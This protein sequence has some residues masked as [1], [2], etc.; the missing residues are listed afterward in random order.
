MNTKKH[1]DKE[2]GQGLAEYALILIGMV[3]S[4][5]LILNIA[6]TSLTAVYCQ[7]ISNLGG[8]GCGYSSTF[9]DANAQED[10]ECWK[11]EDYLVIEDGKACVSPSKETYQNQCSIDFGPA[12]FIMDMKEVSVD[13]HKAK[14]PEFHVVFRAQNENNGYYFS[15]NARSNN[16]RFWKIVDGK[17]ISLDKMRV[18]KEWRDQELNFQIRVE[19]NTFTAY[20]DGEQILQVQ[21]DAYQEGQYGFR[22][23]QSP[24]ICVGEITVQQLPRE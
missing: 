6:G 22:N 1:S 4:V 13:R 12:D 20:K 14:N 3:S 17:R 21:D 24:K 16:V 7:V 2:R 11:K 19:G 10:W 8:S 9:E 18:P 5:I 23:K 15:Y